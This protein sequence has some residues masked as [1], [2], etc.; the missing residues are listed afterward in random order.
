MQATNLYR[1]ERPWI[2]RVIGSLLQFKLI[3]YTISVEVVHFQW[4][5]ILKTALLDLAIHPLVIHDE[6]ISPGAVGLRGNEQIS[7]PVSPSLLT[8]RRI[9]STAFRYLQSRRDTRISRWQ[10]SPYFEQVAAT[11]YRQV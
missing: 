1:I 8:R 2:G 3:F 4:V 10:V 9:T 5:A 11:W 7:A 6:Q